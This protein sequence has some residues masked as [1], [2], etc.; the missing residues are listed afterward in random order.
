MAYDTG[1][2]ERIRAVLTGLR[3]SF[4]EK[5]MFGGITYMVN[6]RMTCGVLKTDLILKLPIEEVEAALASNP[7]AR[8]MDFT[9]KPMKSMIYV[10]PRG[11][12]KDEDLEQLV[13]R[14]VAFAK[15]DQPATKNASPR[16]T[17]HV[18]S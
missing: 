14:A 18:S 4:I 7:H 16:K 15:S 9:G 12:D 6:G 5:K 17:R 10:S 3:T 2:A 11:C 1:L 13:R 8:P